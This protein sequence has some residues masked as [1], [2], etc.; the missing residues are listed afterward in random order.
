[1]TGGVDQCSATAARWGLVLLK[2]AL[3]SWD[4]PKTRK[5]RFGESGMPL[6]S[7]QRSREAGDRDSSLKCEFYPCFSILAR[8]FQLGCASST[9]YS[10]PGDGRICDQRILLGRRQYV[11]QPLLHNDFDP[12]YEIVLSSAPSWAC[13]RARSWENP[14]EGPLHPSHYEIMLQPLLH[15]LSESGVALVSQLVSRSPKE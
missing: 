5:I 10:R 7:C 9:F 1:M 6:A 14:I 4:S 3:L 15:F 8:C 11:S 13:R 2:T 12:P